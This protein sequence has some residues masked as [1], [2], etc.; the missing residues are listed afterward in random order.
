MG[1]KGGYLDNFGAHA[2]MH[3]L[4]TAADYTGPPEQFVDLLRCGIGGHVEILGAQSQHQVADTTADQVGL[5]AIT[6]DLFDNLSRTTGN[7]PG[8]E[9]VPSGADNMRF[10]DNGES[11]SPE[12]F[13]KLL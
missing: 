9:R 12:I 13:G 3:N 6:D 10:A 7:L 11:L 2:D 1:P 4:E 5:K 8:G